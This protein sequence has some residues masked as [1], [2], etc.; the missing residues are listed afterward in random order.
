MPNEK[1]VKKAK[2]GAFTEENIKDMIKRK[3]ILSGNIGSIQKN[4]STGKSSAIIKFR[5]W[6]FVINEDD[7]DCELDLVSLSNFIDR[8]VQ[9]TLLEITGPKTVRAS[10][11]EAQKITQK[12]T[13]E[14]IESGESIRAQIVNVLAHG[15]YVDINGVTGLLK[16]VDFARDSTPIKKVLNV[17]DKI[18]VKY[19]K[20]SSNGT[21]LFE[22]VQK[23]ISPE[24]LTIDD[25]CEDSIV[26]GVVRAVQ[27]FGVFVQVVVDH[28]ALCSNKN[29]QELEEDDKVYVKITMVDKEANKIRGEI[30]PRT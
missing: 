14:R 2:R 18:K 20:R 26:T 7:M 23:Y 11:A 13:I 25:L 4:K 28:D 8:N 30:L 12:S 3:S 27:P 6:K 16:N 22:A 1:N 21:I 17:G 15:A 29:L 19:K 5:G 24:S 9:F 10:R